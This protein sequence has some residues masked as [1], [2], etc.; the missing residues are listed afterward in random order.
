MK[1]N[2]ILIFILFIS[3]TSCERDDICI[4]D[5]T[6]NLTIRFYDSENPTE[7]KAVSGLKVTLVNTTINTLEFSGDSIQL[8]ILNS[9]NTTTYSL[10]NESSGLENN[11]DIITLNYSTDEVFI[12]RSC[13]FKS[14]Y[15]N[16]IYENTEN[17]IQDFQIVSESIQNEN[18]AH[19]KIFH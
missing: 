2:I 10:E 6:P 19:V 14:V 8:P 13:G 3:I 12:G 16:I 7:F 5:I 17:W 4:D 11:V 15:N 9:L 1:K 18:S